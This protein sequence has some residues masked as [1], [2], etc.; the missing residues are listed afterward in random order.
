MSAP[1]LTVTSTAHGSVEHPPSRMLN[2]TSAECN[3]ERVRV[4]ERERQR[5]AVVPRRRARGAPLERREL[6][7]RR[8]L[9]QRQLE[10]DQLAARI[11]AL[12]EPVRVDRP[13]VELCLRRR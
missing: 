12:L 4:P 6:L 3:R 9:G 13:L 10:R 1:V 2:V 7:R 8:L 5:H 11:A